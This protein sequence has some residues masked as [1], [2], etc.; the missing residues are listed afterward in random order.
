MQKIISQDRVIIKR[1]LDLLSRWRK[2]GF[3]KA[4]ARNHYRWLDE[5]IQRFYAREFGFEMK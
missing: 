3:N 2:G 4:E 5:T 1:T